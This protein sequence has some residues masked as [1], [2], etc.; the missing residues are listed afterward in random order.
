MKICFRSKPEGLAGSQ[1]GTQLSGLGGRRPG[2]EK[3][4]GFSVLFRYKGLGLGFQ[5]LEA[6]QREKY[7]KNRVTTEGMSRQLKRFG[8]AA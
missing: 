1:A 4:G 7:R 8:G 2:P 3:R 5:G 6:G